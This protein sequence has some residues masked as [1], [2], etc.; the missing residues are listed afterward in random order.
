MQGP[1]KYVYIH[2]N[3]LW[4]LIKN[5][6][7]YIKPV[8]FYTTFHWFIYFFML[9][10]FDHLHEFFKEH[11]NSLIILSS[12]NIWEEN[13]KHSLLQQDKKKETLLQC[14]NLFCTT[15]Q[16]INLAETTVYKWFLRSAQLLGNPW[17]HCPRHTSRPSS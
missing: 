15:F 3:V 7:P 16:A 5:V 1:I 17:Q 13:Q 8:K 9:V 11:F 2:F 6:S 10:D 12:Q 14:L 4:N